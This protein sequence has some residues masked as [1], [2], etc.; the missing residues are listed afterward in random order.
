MEAAN[1]TESVS[2]LKSMAAAVDLY[3]QHRRAAASPDSA[4]P[5][6]VR[7]ADTLNMTN[8]QGGSA[9]PLVLMKR[10]TEAPMSSFSD[11]LKS[12]VRLMEAGDYE[13]A[14]AALE[15]ADRKL[16]K[17]NHFH[18]YGGNNTVDDDEDNFE[19]PSDPSND[20]PSDDDEEDDSVKKWSDSYTIPGM[21][22]TP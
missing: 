3:N 19:S 9:P 6:P 2:L 13:G 14:N 4:V 18:F 21:G 8:N 12:G 11:L 7:K 5:V 16:N 22:G 1:M 10:T 15:A 17:S 20:D